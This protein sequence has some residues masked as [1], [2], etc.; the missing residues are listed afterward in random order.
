[1]LQLKRTQSP[2]AYGSVWLVQRPAQAGTARWDGWVT[3][4]AACRHFVYIEPVCLQSER[5]C[6]LV[7]ELLVL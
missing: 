3:E 1:M 6:V 7:S 5:C 4:Q 2:E